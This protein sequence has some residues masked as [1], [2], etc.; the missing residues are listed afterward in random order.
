MWNTKIFKTKAAMNQWIEKNNHKH[1][2][3]EIFVNN[4]YGVEYKPLIKFY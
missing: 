2:C 4:A 3:Y 1:Q